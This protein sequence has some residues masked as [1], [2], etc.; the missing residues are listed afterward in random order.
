MDLEGLRSALAARPAV[1]LAV[2]FGSAARGRS[3]PGSDLDLAL[4]LVPAA[5]S[6][7]EVVDAARRVVRRELD[8]VDLD[9]A[10][11]LLRFQIARDGVVLVEREP[12][13]WAR[14]KARAMTD[15][16]DWA[17][18]ARKIHAAYIRR[19]REQVAHGGP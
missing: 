3:G 2:V 19:L 10:P 11:P 18:T 7:R 12:R 15:W 1:K 5:A 4:R 8:V 13:S 17:P 14:F 16:W 9:T 6:R